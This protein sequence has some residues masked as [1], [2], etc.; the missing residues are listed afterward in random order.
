MSAGTS[1]YP[2]DFPN[3]EL[4]VFAL[5]MCGGTTHKVHTENIALKCHELFPGSFS[6]TK[7]PDIPDKD[8][9]RVA[10][11][12]ARKQAQGALVDGRAGRTKGQSAKT[13]REPV[14]D[15]WILTEPGLHFLK[16]H[17]TELRELVRSGRQKDHRQAGRK[18]MRRI[19]EHNLY[20]IFQSD[21]GGFRAPIGQLADL[22]RCRVDAEPGV[23]ER[24]FEKLRLVAAAS[25]DDE[26]AEFVSKL[27]LSY[28]KER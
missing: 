5:A 1:P 8:I 3:R 19:R 10:L 13:K 14:P 11:V 25:E 28:D 7:Y 26:F 17:E 12:D 16:E 21:P 18:E 23:W 20:H 15:G 24:R 6:W 2:T 27:E 9:V 22:M 4:V